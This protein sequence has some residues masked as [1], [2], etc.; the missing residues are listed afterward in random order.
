MLRRAIYGRL[1]RFEDVND[2]ERLR[3]DPANPRFIDDPAT[4][5]TGNGTPPI[6][7][8][9]AFEF[10]DMCDLTSNPDCDDGVL[11]EDDDCRD[12]PNAGQSDFDGDGAGDACDDAARM[13]ASR[14]NSTFATSRLPE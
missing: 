10:Q 7:D 11:N 5:D 14:T 3:V 9:S 2:A 6:V 8:R 1:A 4:D 12:K 13:K